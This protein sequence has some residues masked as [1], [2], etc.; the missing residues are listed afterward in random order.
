MEKEIASLAAETLAVQTILASVLFHLG[1]TDAKVQLAIQRGLDDA[2]NH[3][4][5]IAIRIGKAASPAQIVK[6]IGV[7]EEIRAASL[8]DKAQPRHGV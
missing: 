7:V 4:E 3:V 8:S 1:R 2:A 6:A 5:D